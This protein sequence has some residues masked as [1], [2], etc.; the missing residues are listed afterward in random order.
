M[1]E[2]FTA[3][4]EMTSPKDEKRAAQFESSTGDFAYDTE[5]NTLSKLRVSL[6][7][8]TLDSE[9]RDLLDASTYP[10]ITFIGN[11]AVFKDDEAEIKGTLAIKGTSRPAVLK[12]RLNQISENSKTMSISFQGTFKRTA[13][14]ITD[15]DYKEDIGLT[16]EMNAF[17]VRKF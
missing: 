1:P 7:T 16:L 5:T 10:E 2:Q 15:G 9:F 14:G 11:S 8:S 3:R 12:A 4:L 13:F 17:L 6:A